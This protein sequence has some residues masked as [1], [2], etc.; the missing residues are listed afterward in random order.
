MSYT[1]L[2]DSSNTL[3]AI[4]LL[5]DGKFIYRQSYYAWQRQSELMIP[6]IE[7]AFKETNISFLNI[8]EVMVTKGPGSYTGV[9][10][11]LT[12]AKTIATVNPIIKCKA[13]S[14]LMALGC[15]TESYISLINARS[16]RSYIAIYEKGKCIL[17]DQIVTNEEALLL[18]EKYK[19]NGFVLKG[20]LEYLNL[21]SDYEILDGMASYIDIIEVENDILKLKPL[22]LKD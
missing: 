18:I 12:I 15:K 10:I 14:S 7:K 21:E 22:Y 20:D 8:D 11:A 17:N 5:S 19:R 6:E 4:G 1:L 9:R 13:I 16:N 2:L 3:L